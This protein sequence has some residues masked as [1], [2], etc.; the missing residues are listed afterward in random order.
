MSPHR[1]RSVNAL[2]V[3]GFKVTVG[4]TMPPPTRSDNPRRAR[5]DDTR[6]AVDR[7]EMLLTEAYDEGV[8]TEVIRPAAVVPEQ[9]ARRV[10]V[11]LALRGVSDLG[12][13]CALGQPVTEPMFAI[14]VSDRNA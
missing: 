8:V 11:E 13:L 3:V 9:A 6:R 12:P 5:H 7:R 1:A 14:M 10:L 2:A 4:V